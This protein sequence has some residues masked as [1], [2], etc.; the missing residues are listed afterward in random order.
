[1]MDRRIFLLGA[2]VLAM[3]GPASATACGFDAPCCHGF[4]RLP[5]RVNLPSKLR[6]DR[7]G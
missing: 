6:L 7:S 1:M 4:T 2:S 5:K 3:T